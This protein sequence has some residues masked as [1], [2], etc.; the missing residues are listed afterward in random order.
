[1]FKIQITVSLILLA[2]LA[3]CEPNHYSDNIK[4]ATSKTQEQQKLVRK[5]L[6]FKEQLDIKL[7]EK[8]W[9]KRPDQLE[10]L[11]DNGHVV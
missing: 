11:D 1:M 10:I 6:T 4:P 7:I 9:I 3:G 5:S 2:L 8:G